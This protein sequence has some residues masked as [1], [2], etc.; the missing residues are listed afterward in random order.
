[1]AME[2]LRAREPVEIG[3]RDPDTEEVCCAH[4]DHAWLAR[5]LHGRVRGVFDTNSMLSFLQSKDSK[6]RK[7]RDPEDVQASHVPDHRPGRDDSVDDGLH[8]A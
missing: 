6:D 1:M 4:A 2:R 5:I 7:H 8:L 3:V